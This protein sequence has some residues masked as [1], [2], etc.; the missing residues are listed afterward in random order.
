MQAGATANL[1]SLWALAPLTGDK[2]LSPCCLQAVAASTAIPTLFQYAS[3]AYGTQGSTPGFSTAAAAL[4]DTT[5]TMGGSIS[6][7]HRWSSDQS[8]AL[9]GH[10]LSMLHKL[11]SCCGAEI[12]AA[13]AVPCLLGLAAS[14]QAGPGHSEAAVQVVAMLARASAQL[15]LGCAEQG[16]VSELL[17]LAADLEGQPESVRR[18]ALV[19]LSQ[20]REGLV[21]GTHAHA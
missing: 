20:V 12:L 8:N 16:A 2:C 19:C 14:R 7:R 11:A 4:P 9:R 6:P 1:L 15:Q 21:V 13:D 18:A 5:S 3:W 17:R 10:A